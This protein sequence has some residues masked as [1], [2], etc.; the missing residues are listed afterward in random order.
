M[1]ATIRKEAAVYADLLQH[2]GTLPT[3]N[4]EEPASL[5]T[6]RVHWSLAWNLEPY[7][8]RMKKNQLQCSQEAFDGQGFGNWKLADEKATVV[9]YGHNT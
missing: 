2:S 5:L 9:F 4:E 8:K 3:D 1:S 6:Q 7:P